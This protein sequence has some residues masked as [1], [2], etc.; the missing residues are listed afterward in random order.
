MLPAITSP[1]TTT[2]TAN[3]TMSTPSAAELKNRLQE[4]MAEFER[5][6]AVIEAAEA[7]VRAMEKAEQEAREKAE[8]ERAEKERAEKEQAEKERAEKELAE[9]KGKVSPHLVSSKSSDGLVEACSRRR[10][11][12]GG[13]KED[14]RRQDGGGPQGRRPL[15]GK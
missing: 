2:I 15:E 3:C 5:Q 9:K 1:P 11:R 8:R 7:D 10:R 4:Q 13:K 6:R 12:G 14:V